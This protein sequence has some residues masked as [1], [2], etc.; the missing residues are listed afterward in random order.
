[1]QF[2]GE[3]PHP[4]DPLEY[5][6]GV[7]PYTLV[8]LKMMRALGKIKDK[9]NWFNKINDETIREKWRKELESLHPTQVQFI[10]D[11]LM[12]SA[13]LSDEK[14]SVSPVDGVW[15]SD[16]IIDEELCSELASAVLTLENSDDEPDW[17]PGSN[18]QMLDLLHPS[19]N[20]FV[21][22]VSKDSEGN[23]VKVFEHSVSGKAGQYTS[24]KYQWLP[25]EV[26]V[27]ENGECKITSPIN[28]YPE[29]K[30]YSV[31]EKIL[32]CF[33]PLFKNVLNEL[34]NPRPRRQ[35]VS[36]NSDDLYEPPPED[37][38]DAVIDEWYES[39]VP[40]VP[41]EVP[42]FEPSNQ[43][44]LVELNG[45]KLQ[46]I[47]KLA[48]IVLTEDKPKY[49]GGSWHVEGM[50]N[51][52]IVASGIYYW[53]S[54]NITTSKLTFRTAVREPDYEQSDNE[55][56]GGVFGLEDEG[57]LV[58]EIG[59]VT[60]IQNRSVCWPNTLQHKV[61][62]FELV[63]TTEPGVRKILVF[64]LIDPAVRILS[65]ANVPQQNFPKELRDKYRDELMKERKFFV[66]QNTKEH[67]EREFS[68]CEH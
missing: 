66:D 58:Q 67:F 2:T 6:Q 11:E 54:E 35:K 19:V 22:G 24:E 52:H 63:D 18:Q 1:M 41:Q 47:F 34:V 59:S 26:D 68:L 23:T 43:E 51:E 4:F 12:H 25:S 55:G 50:R 5:D 27:G 21:N 61:Q 49:K 17:H 42:E 20:P 31:F 16:K 32:E 29:G 56:V 40:K 15:Q 3:F 57:P 37:E 13:K 33:I 48:N 53:Q 9:R 46:V 8:E 64:F 38:D 10:L 65:T 28:N 45:R 30:L 7:S 62:D 14:L 39:R 36:M 44:K 60:C